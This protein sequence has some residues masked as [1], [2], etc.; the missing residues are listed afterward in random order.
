ME[1][2]LL[3]IPKPVP[4]ED[5]EQVPSDD[6]YLDLKSGGKAL[7]SVWFLHLLSFVCQP[8]KQMK[9]T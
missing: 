3:P 9:D 7:C 5:L 8:M 1:I 4:K 6:F 2:E